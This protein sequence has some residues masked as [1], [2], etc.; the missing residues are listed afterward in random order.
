MFSFR[1]SKASDVYFKF[2]KKKN[3][4]TT[5][6]ETHRPKR[7]GWYR[8]CPAQYSML[9]SQKDWKTRWKTDLDGNTITMLYFQMKLNES[10]RLRE[11]KC[12]ECRRNFIHKP[13]I[14]L[15]IS[16]NLQFRQHN[17]THFSPLQQANGGGR[18]NWPTLCWQLPS[19]VC[20]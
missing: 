2:L 9:H 3:S 6:R 15:Y 18:N 1:E 11:N 8:I 7:M 13:G 19:L 10:I 17:H 12:A 5:L 20:H 16:R 14:L 4:M